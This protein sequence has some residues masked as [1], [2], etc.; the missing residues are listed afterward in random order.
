ME[1]RPSILVICTGNAAR[2][3]MAE[4]LLKHICGDRYEI[5]SAGTHPW[6][7]R[8]GAIEVMA[9][10]GID[11]SKN[12]S[13]SVNEFLDRDIDYVLTVCDSA[14]AE[15]PHFPART[16]L[17]HHSIPDPVYEVGD[18]EARREAFRSAR[19][20]IKAYLIEEFLPQIEKENAA[21]HSP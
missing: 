9:E 10:I 3:Q 21:K 11:I 5:H 6:E 13:K 12:R 19:D 15:C 18:L 16:K 1:N 7:V 20:E 17:I 2:S 8:P 14:R 4:A